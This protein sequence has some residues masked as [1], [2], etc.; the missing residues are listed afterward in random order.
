MTVDRDKPVP[1]L[2]PLLVLLLDFIVSTGSLDLNC[3]PGF[4]LLVRSRPDV[5]IKPEVVRMCS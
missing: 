5:L 4:L 3:T 2:F 1:A